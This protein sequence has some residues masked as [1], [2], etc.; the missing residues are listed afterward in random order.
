[1]KHVKGMWGTGVLVVEGSENSKTGPVSV[2]YVSQGSCPSSCVFMGNGCYAEDGPM[3]WAATSKVNGSGAGLTTTQLAT[4]E[5]RLIGELSGHY[6]LRVHVVGDC[7]DDTSASIV[8]EA[9]AS[10][11]RDH[12]QWA[13]TYTHAWREVSRVSWGVGANVLASC[14][15]AAQVREAW[16]RGYAAVLVVGEFP[17]KKR[18][19]VDELP[20]IPCP[21]QTTGVKCIDC[22]LCSRE[23]VLRGRAV[24]GF[25]AHGVRA[26]KVRET[27]ANIQEEVRS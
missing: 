21:E 14:E 24:I 4:E 1:M 9:M 3:S 23:E 25:A 11:T 18:Y 16:G 2:T 19:L 20:V 26:G 7:A 17:S 5:A 10:Y 6:P 22:R 27:I 8:G 15:T 13:W 12:D